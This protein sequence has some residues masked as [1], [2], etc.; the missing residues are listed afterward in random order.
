[1]FIMIVI[2]QIDR[3]IHYD[4]GQYMVK[5]M[6]LSYSESTWEEEEYLKSEADLAAIQKFKKV[7][8]KQFN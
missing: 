5:W 2:P 8:D 7:N 6:G 1:M 3:V 4:S